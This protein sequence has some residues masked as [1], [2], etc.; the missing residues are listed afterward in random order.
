MPRKEPRSDC[1]RLPADGQSAPTR[2]QTLTLKAEA[3]A[4]NFLPF[5]RR[6]LALDRRPTRI[7]VSHRLVGRRLLQDHLPQLAVDRSGQFALIRRPN[8]NPIIP[9]AFAQIVA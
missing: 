2:G 8:A 6:H 9:D 7:D 5:L 4:E 3:L 1:L